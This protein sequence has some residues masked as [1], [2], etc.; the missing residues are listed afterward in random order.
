MKRENEC[1]QG[2]DEREDA[3]IPVAAREEDEQDGAAQGDKRY[4]RQNPAIEIRRTHVN[5]IQIM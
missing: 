3:D 2:T 4:Q 1:Q 5:A